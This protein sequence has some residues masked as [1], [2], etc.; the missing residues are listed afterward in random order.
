MTPRGGA[1]GWPGSHFAPGADRPAHQRQHGIVRVVAPRFRRSMSDQRVLAPVPAAALALVDHH[2]PVGRLAVQRSVEVADDV[3][4]QGL[5]LRQIVVAVLAA[6][7]G[8][9]H[10]QPGMRHLQSMSPADRCANPAPRT[11]RAKRFVR[12]TGM[13]EERLPRFLEGAHAQI[14]RRDQVGT[15]FGGEVIEDRSRISAPAAWR[16]SEVQLDVGLVLDEQAIDG[17]AAPGILLDER[18]RQG[19][20]GAV[21]R[22]G[23]AG[24]PPSVRLPLVLS[25]AGGLHGLA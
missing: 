25:Q 2:V 11:T 13:G 5:R 24:R 17:D 16:T 8:M 9:H 23:V 6:G 7:L 21:D 12:E 18:R 3:A 15:E 22:R 10:V 14:S 19:G 4:E 20:V 1:V